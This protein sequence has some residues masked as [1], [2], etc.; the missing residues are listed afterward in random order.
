LPRRA[1]R[2]GIHAGLDEL[3]GAEALDR[4][5][6]LGH[7]YMAHAALADLLQQLVS[8][9]DQTANGFAGRVCGWFKVRSLLDCL[10]ERSGEA[11][12]LFLTGEEVLQLTGQVGMAGEEFGLIG[13]AAGFAGAEVGGDHFLQALFLRSIHFRFE[14]H[15]SLQILQEFPQAFDAAVQQAGGCPFA[16]TQLTRQL[17][18][19]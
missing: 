12:E 13:M 1:A 14:G 7:P 16:A 2:S 11:A 19:R 5:A 3:D 17:R 4:L 6:L 18:Q 15:N 8:A 10:A 9:S